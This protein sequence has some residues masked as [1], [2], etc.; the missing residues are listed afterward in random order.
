MRQLC[1]MLVSGIDPPGLLGLFQPTPPTGVDVSF[2]DL[3]FKKKLI[4]EL[5]VW[6]ICVGISQF[7]LQIYVLKINI[8]QILLPGQPFI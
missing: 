5:C 8:G 2:L 3:R 7:C 6:Y 4:R 1:D